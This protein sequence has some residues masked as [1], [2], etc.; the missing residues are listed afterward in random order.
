MKL[1]V[2]HL[3][4]SA[5]YQG[6]GYS[7]QFCENMEKTV[8]WLWNEES[9]CEKE[10]RMAQLII[11]PDVICQACPNLIGEACVLDGDSVVS[12]DAR[13]AE[14]LHLQLDR[15]YAVSKLLRHVKENLTEEIF[16][17]SCHK[18]EW[19]HQKLCSYEKLAGKYDSLL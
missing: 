1:R 2:H 14:A 12:K 4:C 8:K 7:R 10:E 15:Q 18:C 9:L 5:L 6:E 16:E 17:T 13:L 3:F 19:Y 11:R